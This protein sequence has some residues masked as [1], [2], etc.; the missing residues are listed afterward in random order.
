MTR[1]L[2]AEAR[3]L[4]AKS[5]GKSALAGCLKETTNHRLRLIRENVSLGDRGPRLRSKLFGAGGRCYWAPKMS[6]DFPHLDWLSLSRSH[7]LG[8]RGYHLSC[9]RVSTYTMGSEDREEYTFVCPVCDESLEVNDSMKDA[10]V[11]R[12]CVICGTSVTTEAFRRNSS[13]DSS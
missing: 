11:E 1:R 2:T 9:D 5:F 6:P 4:G 12:G 3:S 13:S 7:I 10:L 8:N